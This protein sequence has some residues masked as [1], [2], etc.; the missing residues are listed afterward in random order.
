MTLCGFDL[1]L[2]QHYISYDSC[3]CEY[4]KFAHQKSLENDLNDSKNH[5]KTFSSE[6]LNHM[7]HNQ[8][9]SFDR[10]G[11]SFDKYVVSSTN[12]ASL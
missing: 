6:K 10:T 3:A 5:L 12:V 11:L 1:T 8:K 7:S 4:I 9:H 2:A